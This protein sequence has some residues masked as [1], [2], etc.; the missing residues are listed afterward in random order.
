M[1]PRMYHTKAKAQEWAAQMRETGWP[2][3]RVVAASQLDSD[4]LS[5]GGDERWLIRVA[6]GAYELDDSTIGVPR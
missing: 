5:Y 1:T 6:P 4:Y 3:A 2:N